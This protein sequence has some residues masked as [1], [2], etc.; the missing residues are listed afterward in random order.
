MRRGRRKDVFPPRSMPRIIGGSGEAGPLGPSPRLCQV[1]H[2]GEGVRRDVVARAEVRASHLV[3][4]DRVQA[5][6]HHDQ[7]AGIAVLGASVLQPAS[8]HCNPTS[9]LG[10]GGLERFLFHPSFFPFGS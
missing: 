1:L 5:R 2:R 7:K 4:E 9:R 6:D 8:G 3:A 10:V